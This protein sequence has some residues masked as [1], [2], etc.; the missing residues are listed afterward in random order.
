MGKVKSSVLH[1]LSK[2]RDSGPLLRWDFL[3]NGAIL[4]YYNRRRPG[5]RD[6]LASAFQVAGATGV[7]HH[8]WLIFVFLVETGFRHIGQAGLELLTSDDPTT[9]ASQSLV[10]SPLDDFSLMVIVFFVQE[11][12]HFLWEQKQDP[13]QSR[14]LFLITVREALW[15]AEAG[16][17]RGK[18]IKIILANMTRF[19]HVGQAGLE[20]P[21]S[22]DPP[23]LASKVLGLQA[24]TVSPRLECSGNPCLPHS[25]NSH[26]SASQVAGTTGTHHHLLSRLRQ[27]NHFN[28][29]GRSCSEQRS[30]HCTP[31]WVTKQ[32]CHYVAQAGLELLSSSDPPAL[33]SQSTGIT[34]MSHCT[35]LKEWRLGTVV[36]ACNLSTLGGWVGRSLEPRSSRPAWPTWQN[37]VSTKNTKF[38]RACG[39]MSVVSATQK[40]EGG[41]LLKQKHIKI[42]TLCHPDQSTV[43]AGVQWHGLSSLQT[44]PPGSNDFPASASRIAGI[45]GAGHHT[46]LIFAFLK[47]DYRAVVNV[48]SV[49]SPKERQTCQ[50]Q[51][52]MPVIPALSEAEAGGSPELPGR[53]RQENHWN[54][55]GGDCGETRLCHC[56]KEKKRR[57]EGRKETQAGKQAKKDPEMSDEG[58]GAVAHACDLSTLGGRGGRITRS[59]DETILA[60]MMES[61]CITQAGVWW[62]SLSSLQPPPP[63]FKQFSALASRVAEITGACHHTRLHFVF[64]VEMGWSLTLSP[65]L[66][67]SGAFSAQCKL[68]L[69]G[70]SNSPA[71]ASQVFQAVLAVQFLLWKSH[72]ESYL[73]GWAS[74]RKKQR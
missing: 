1:R 46:Q 21:T 17:S 40:V 58:I 49:C 15:E 73:L 61:R 42:W 23:A 70:S 59:R 47:V 56:T 14:E 37:P 67:C 30:C 12:L 39:H 29:G 45:T 53:L 41:G 36:H 10:V 3:C 26:A 68:R 48:K 55:G 5:S 44:L 18:E 50:V 9:L 31:A 66:E 60:N 2:Q 6:S 22:G 11:K 38:S 13:P 57:K 35:R 24:L 27:E 43:K 34:D 20:L 8:A 54:L 71:S 25:S 51:W 63:E 28:P 72:L 7:C 64:L 69:L 32:G 52:L 19:H 62:L 4:A 74:S 33:A 65:R 16:G